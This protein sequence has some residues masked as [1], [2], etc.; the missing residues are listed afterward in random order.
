[1]SIGLIRRGSHT[2]GFLEQYVAGSS[3]TNPKAVSS[4]PVTKQLEYLHCVWMIEIVL[5]KN[6]EPNI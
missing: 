4:L 5:V 2:V 1:M 3:N 6:L